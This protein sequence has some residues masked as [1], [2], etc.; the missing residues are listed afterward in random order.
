MKKLYMLAALSMPLFAMQDSVHSKE[1]QRIFAATKVSFMARAGAVQL[2]HLDLQC[3]VDGACNLN[4]VGTIGNYRF[5]PASVMTQEFKYP[6]QNE[7]LLHTL[8]EHGTEFKY[9][10]D[11]PAYK[12]RSEIYTFV[13]EESLK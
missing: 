12:L 1:F 3:I 13:E 2:A 8:I 11:I 6:S 9:I 5:V 4:I 7:V 10:G